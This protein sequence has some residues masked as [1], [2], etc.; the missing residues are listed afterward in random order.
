[1]G[2]SLWSVLFSRSRSFQR[3][4]R[5]APIFEA[6]ERFNRRINAQFS[7]KTNS[8]MSLFEQRYRLGGS[9]EDGNWAGKVIYQYANDVDWSAKRNYSYQA[10]DLYVGE[11]DYTSDQGTATLG[12][13]IVAKGGARLL[14]EST[15][16]Q[17]SKSFDALR[18]HNTQ[19][20]FFAGK[21]GLGSNAADFSR[22]VGGSYDSRFGETMLIYKHDRWVNHEDFYTADQRY[23]FIKGAG[24]IKIE[25]EFEGAAQRGRANGLDMDAWFLHARVGRGMI[26]NWGTY[27]EANSFSGGQRGNTTFGFD[28][29]YGATHDFLGRMDIFGPRN[30]NN[31]EAAATWK[32]PGKMVGVT[33]GR[34]W[35]RDPSGGFYNTSLGLNSFP[36]GPLID[37]TGT[38]GRDL[39]QEEDLLARYDVNKHVYIAFEGG[40]FQPGKY[41]RSFTG[42]FGKSELWSVIYAGYKY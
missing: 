37:P 7:D 6:R 13:Q 16:A 15:F 40:L 17:R 35:L 34:Y 21:V 3:F 29:L 26:K 20:D 36:G 11:A 12:R 4:W 9:F 31:V 32:Q 23:Y 42:A 25:G 30:L 38:K 39:G 1:M 14:E 18:L 19:W 41:I 27:L 28:N 33:F 24:R 8:D 10:S 2:A 5:I 22:I